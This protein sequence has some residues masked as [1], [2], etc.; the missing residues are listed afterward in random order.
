MINRAV[1]AIVPKSVVAFSLLVALLAATAA[2]QGQTTRQ[3]IFNVP[4][5]FTAGGESLPA[6]EYIIRRADQAG[7]AYFIQRR[8]G[9]AAAAVSVKNTSGAKPAGGQA[10]LTFNV[11]GGQYFLTQ[12]QPEKYGVS[13]EFQRSR[14]ERELARAATEDS[15]VVT[16]ADQE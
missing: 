5:Q 6:G 10:R 14:A 7:L 12:A 15:H 11:Y 13:V 8:D 1:R 16:V 2:T 9:R 4:F 3:A